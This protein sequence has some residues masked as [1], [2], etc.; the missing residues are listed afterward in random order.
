MWESFCVRNWTTCRW[1]GWVLRCLVGLLDLKISWTTFHWQSTHDVMEDLI[2][3]PGR[4]WR[5]WSSQLLFIRAA[6]YSVPC[7]LPDRI[8]KPDLGPKMYNAYGECRAFPVLSI[9]SSSVC[10]IFIRFSSL[11]SRRDNKPPSGY[12]RCCQRHGMYAIFFDMLHW[13]W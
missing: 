6:I 12:V 3:L 9:S 10:G 13:F 1:N 11:P 4:H 8:V 5:C 2:L 7:R